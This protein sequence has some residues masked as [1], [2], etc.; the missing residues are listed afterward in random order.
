MI[1][2]ATALSAPGAFP[3]DSEDFNYLV[4]RGIRD[5]TGPA[6]GVQLWGFVR[7][8]QVSEGIHFR[9]WS[10]AFVMV[11]PESDTRLVF[12]SADIGSITHTLHSEVVERL[13][14]DYGNL[15]T[16]DN[17]ILSATHT[18][19]GPGGYWHYGVDSPIGAPF[20]EAHYD[21]IVEG[22]VDSIRAAHDGLQPGA[23][24]V[25]RGTVNGAGANRSM[26]AYLNNP[27]DER[28]RY[29]G[30]TDTD[31]T[32]LKFVDAT[33]ATGTLN[34]FAVHPTSMTYNNRLISGDHKGNASYE[35]EKREGTTYASTS[36]FVA[37]F[38]QSNCGDVT[39]NLNLDNTG[40]GEDEFE[41]THI[42]AE[43]Q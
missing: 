15:Y 5:I 19:S 9:L 36:D 2:I 31:M 27:A 3:T 13:R 16:A 21:A 7:E 40:P 39:A 33:G 41:T 29:A 23:I 38:A 32:L 43:R 8:G 17:V 4:G 6:V 34:W 20:L 35:F 26:P 42:I 1:S 10:R 11:D 37:A 18:H 14:A 28:A 24:L 12:V 25:N 30:P 22:I